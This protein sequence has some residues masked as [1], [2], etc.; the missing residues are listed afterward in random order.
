[1]SDSSLPSNFPATAPAAGAID[2]SCRLPLL[3]LFAGAA[4]WL[5]VAAV[6]ALLA[7]MSF[8]KPDMFADCIWLSYG[9]ILPFAKTALLYGFCLPA[10]YG[11][12]LWLAARLSRTTLAGSF[13]G[14]LAAKLWHLGVFIGASGILCGASTGHEGFEL[15]TYAAMMLLVSSVLLGVVGLLTI[16]QRTERQ[17][18]PS[19]WF[20]ITGLLWFPWILSTAI[21]LLGVAPVRGVA[22]ATVLAWY[23]NNLQF[24]VLGLFGMGAALYFIP[25]LAGKPLHS[26]HLALFA[27]FTL[28]LFGS[29]GGL[30]IGGPFPAWMGSLSSI[31]AVFAVAPAL[32]H[33]DNLRR[34]CCLKAPEAEAKFFS[35]GVPLLVLATVLAALGALA[36][37][38][39]FTLFRPGHVTLLVQGFFAMVAL[40]GIYHVFPRVTDLKWPLAGLVRAH[41]WLAL[42]GV[43]LIALPYGVGGWQQGAKLNQASLPFV[44][45]AKSTLMP[46][47]LATLG[48]LLWALGSLW[49]VLNVGALVYRSLRACLKPFVADVTA[50]VPAPEVKA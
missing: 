19:L 12:A 43:L 25:K 49:L 27:L 11:L 3:A 33:M 8:H 35:F 31:A 13:V 16:H 17:L 38:T 41:L 23:V 5:F 36:S 30:G 47:R 7:S 39:H 6:A 1:M 10:G 29:W 44:D 48:E 14:A 20:V 32:A 9:R 26:R 21:L 24:V 2:A 46:I 15:P 22:Q 4:L 40:G 18:Y 50:V 42:A 45:V 37:L 34:T 28:V